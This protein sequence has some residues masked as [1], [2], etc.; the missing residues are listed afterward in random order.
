M[1]EDD[2]AIEAGGAGGLVLPEGLQDVV[3]AE[4]AATHFGIC[5]VGIGTN[6][7]REIDHLPADGATPGGDRVVPPF[8]GGYKIMR[9]S[10]V[11]AEGMDGGKI[12]LKIGVKTVGSDERAIAMGPV[13]V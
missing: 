6:A 3:A 2:G 9:T 10:G 13:G 12:V 11:D 8:V 7:G 4:I 1:D 5:I